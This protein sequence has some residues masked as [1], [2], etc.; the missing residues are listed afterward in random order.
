MY[1][2]VKNVN[3]CYY[4]SIKISFVKNNLERSARQQFKDIK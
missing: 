1:I 3:T 4:G 2:F